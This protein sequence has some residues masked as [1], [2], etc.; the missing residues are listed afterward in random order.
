MPGEQTEIERNKQAARRPVFLNLLQIHLP[1]GGV[2]SILH[3]ISGVLLVFSI[4]LFIYFLQLLNADAKNFME[5][6]GFLQTIPGKL[7]LSLVTWMLIQHSLS[8][9][10][11]LMM[12]LDYSYKKSIARKTASLAFALSVTLILLTGVMIW[13]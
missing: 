9:I 12:D 2:L 3:R 4:P 8:G 10:R 1:L 11:H 7:V 13:L 6:Q 5:V